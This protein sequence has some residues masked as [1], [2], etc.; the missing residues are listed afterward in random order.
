MTEH[1]PKHVKRLWL[2]KWGWTAE[3]VAERERASLASVGERDPARSR[4]GPQKK[5][6]P[7]KIEEARQLRA[8]G[9]TIKAIA[10]ELGVSKTTI[11]NVTR[12][13]K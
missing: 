10:A 9:W 11:W 8:D 1:I 7:R 2:T 3:Q 6:G 5:L 4:V 12:G 13:V